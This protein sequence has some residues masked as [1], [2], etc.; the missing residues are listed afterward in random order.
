[1][2]SSRRRQFAIE[3]LSPEGQKVVRQG[4]EAGR[5]LD[6]V[7]S[8]LRRATGEQA[9]VSS[10]HRWWRW[11]KTK[12]RFAERQQALDTAVELVKAVPDPR[13]ISALNNALKDHLLDKEAELKEESAL[14]LMQHLL[15][16]ER[17]ELAHAKLKVAQEIARAETIK[18]VASEK[19]AEA[20]ITQADAALMSAEAR[21]KQL[22]ATMA[23]AAKTLKEAEGKSADGKVPAEVLARV[24]GDLYG[25]GGPAGEATDG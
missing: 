22:E 4:M 8:E 16:M 10:I 21:V 5:T 20:A 25:L 12:V 2:A 17:V 13:F 11:E 18:A 19:K 9:S 14:E 7:A 24:R 6:A 15:K 3:R 1:M 23:K